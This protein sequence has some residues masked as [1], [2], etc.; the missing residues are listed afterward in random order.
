MNF[1]KE[2]TKLINLINENKISNIHDIRDTLL[3]N[4]V[5][6]HQ[7]GPNFGYLAQD[8][9]T[10]IEKT[11]SFLSI[12]SYFERLGFLVFHKIQ[13]ANINFIYE[14]YQNGSYI[15]NEKLDSIIHDYLYIRFTTSPLLKN[16][17]ENGYKTSDELKTSKENFSRNLISF[18]TILIAILSL[19]TSGF[20]AKIN[21]RNSKLDR[22]TKALQTLKEN[23]TVL[24]KDILSIS[25]DNEEIESILNL[26]LKLKVLTLLSNDQKNR[27]YSF[28][29]IQYYYFKHE[30]EKLT[31]LLNHE[32]G[33]NL[34]VNERNSKNEEL[35]KVCYMIRKNIELHDSL[36]NKNI[37]IRNIL[38][39]SE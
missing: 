1:N 13:N 35:T 12:I 9:E 3:S 5:K 36:K 15:K 31:N 18:I 32:I 28:N 38:L 21:Y 27:A 34:S 24:G 4:L 26:D 14:S 17:I 2:E 22:Q 23:G 20:I 10:I 11:R 37:D 29:D 7:Y 16:Y 19:L 25:Y 39:Y 33:N 8:I 6:K 30:F